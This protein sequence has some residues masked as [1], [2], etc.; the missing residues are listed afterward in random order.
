MGVRICPECNAKNPAGAPLCVKCG[1]VITDQKVVGDEP[2]TAEPVSAGPLAMEMVGVGQVVVTDIQMPFWSMVW[3]MLKWAIAA[4]PATLILWFVIG[5]IAT[6][7][8]H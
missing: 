5:V 3:F 2:S 7:V 1:C 8:R 4:I 6:A